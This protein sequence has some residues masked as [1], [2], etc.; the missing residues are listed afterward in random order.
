[1]KRPS[2]HRARLLALAG[3]LVTLRV[4]WAYAPAGRY[5]YDGNASLYDTKSHLRWQ[6]LPAFNPQLD[7]TSA[8]NYCPTA[9]TD[10]VTWRPPT[11]K[12][13]AT[14]ID[15]TAFGDGGTGPAVDPDSFYAYSEI[16]WSSTPDPQG[17]AAAQ[18]PD[19]GTPVPLAF[20]VDFSTGHIVRSSMSQ[21]YRVWCVSDATS[22]PD[23][24]PPS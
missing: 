9:T 12:E 1:M 15:F 17:T 24:G 22:V 10:G 7:W 13:L 11:V 4:A 6:T 8:V 14:L 3:L 18:A 2:P 19:G 5:N 23:A 16:V 20:G 21:S